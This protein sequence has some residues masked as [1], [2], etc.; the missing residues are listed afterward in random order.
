MRWASQALDVVRRA[1]LNLLRGMDLSGHAK[2]LK[3][4]RYALWKNPEDLA[5]RQAAK[6]AWIAATTTASTGRADSR[7]AQRSPGKRS[8]TSHRR[9]TMTERTTTTAGDREPIAGDPLMSDPA[10]GAVPATPM[11]PPPSGA[12]PGEVSPRTIAPAPTEE[13]GGGKVKAA[14]IVATAAALANKAR[15]EA[16]KVVNQ[17]RE[18]RVAGRCVIVTEVDGRFLAIGP[19]KNED[20]ARGDVFKVGGTPHIA[21]LVTD[22]AFFAPPEQP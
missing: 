21:E 14:A 1:V 10:A 16:P 6:L 13:D 22:T 3:N 11:A 2:R 15:K 17:L 7:L 20:T 9:M 18:R 19:Y 4:C 8:I 12:V 5:A